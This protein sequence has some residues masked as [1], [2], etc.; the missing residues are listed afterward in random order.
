MKRFLMVVLALMVGSLMAVTVRMHMS[1][2]QYHTNDEAKVVTARVI[3]EYI[4]AIPVKAGYLESF[5][6]ETGWKLMIEGNALDM[7]KFYRDELGI[8]ACADGMG[9]HTPRFWSASEPIDAPA[10][11]VVVYATFWIDP[12]RRK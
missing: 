5:L 6:A 7:S 1:T 9:D 12:D 4:L 8:I 11:S 10:S 3:D 2:K